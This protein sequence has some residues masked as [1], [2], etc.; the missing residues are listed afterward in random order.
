MSARWYEIRL[1]NA[2]RAGKYATEETPNEHKCSEMFRLG[3]KCLKGDEQTCQTL[4]SHCVEILTPIHDVL[5]TLLQTK[6]HIYSSLR[7]HKLYLF[8]KQAIGKNCP[9]KP[10]I[11]LVRLALR[12]WEGLGWHPRN[13]TVML[14]VPISTLFC[15][16]CLW[17]GQSFS[18]TLMQKRE[19][20][21][22][23]YAICYLR[24]LFIKKY[25]CKC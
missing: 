21:N 22:I 20:S 4:R 11:T 24:Y 17:K 10:C 1:Q 2:R 6:P 18:T 3:R 8:T 5:Y 19:K 25:S 9:L 13:V 14:C 15:T 12:V 23:S 16:L 7:D